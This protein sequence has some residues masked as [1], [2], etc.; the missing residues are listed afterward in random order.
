[1]I[2]GAHAILYSKDADADRAF[3]RDVLCFPGVDAGEGWLIFAL[4][5]SELAVHPA[6][7]ND[8][9][10]VYLMTDDVAEEMRRL[11]SHGI[12]C[13]APRVLGWGTLTQL[14]LPGGGLLGLYQP[15]HPLA[16]APKKG[17]M[18][19][20][21]PR[22]AANRTAR[23]RKPTKGGRARAPRRRRGRSAQA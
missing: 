9:H 2:L 18:S 10:E 6:E 22:R 4:P 13:S 15:R 3:L 8:E 5:P 20:K 19:A 12:A 17:R 16:H 21:S 1:M 23:G 11:E 14:T 7:A